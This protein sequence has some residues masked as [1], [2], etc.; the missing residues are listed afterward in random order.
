MK[1]KIANK[2][3]EIHFL[4]EKEYL[5]FFASYI[6]DEDTPDFFVYQEAYEEDSKK[7]DLKISS[8]R[9]DMYELSGID[10]HY[11]K[12]INDETYVGKIVYGD[13]LIFAS[14]DL[15]DVDLNIKL[16]HYI[17]TRLLSNSFPCA[18]LK[19]TVVCY[20]GSGIFLASSSSLAYDFAKL[21]EKNYDLVYINTHMNFITKENDK[22]YV[23]GNP[24]CEKD[25]INNNVIVELNHIVFFYEDK[26][27]S[28]RKLE[29][30]ES[31]LK[32]TNHI[33]TPQD[34]KSL[35]GCNE[36]LDSIVKLDNYVLYTKQNKKSIEE[37]KR[38]IDAL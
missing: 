23:Y 36:V 30:T 17:V 28:S 19:G 26:I 31:F 21:W 27:V 18:L 6:V 22:L 7:G 13:K 9:Y 35:E 32:L 25:G 1:I 34:V 24:W 29:S 33:V 38:I 8:K 2:V 37:L 12:S 20:N 4:F 16:L 14:K 3:F 11:H 10:T 5:P 15:H